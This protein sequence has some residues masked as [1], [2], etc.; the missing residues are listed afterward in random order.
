MIGSVAGG[1]CIRNAAMLHDV[2]VGIGA[3]RSR[4]IALVVPRS[5][6]RTQS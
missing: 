2:L 4:A 5:L 3:T 6:D 1:R